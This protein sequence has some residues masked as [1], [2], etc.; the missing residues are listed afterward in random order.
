MAAEE[1]KVH[2][3]LGARNFGPWPFYAFGLVEFVVRKSP[4]F[5]RG[6]RRVLIFV[7]PS[8]A[9]ALRTQRDSACAGVAAAL[10]RRR[11]D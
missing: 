11:H 3:L 6:K 9:G 2:L 7:P 4:P 10:L 5:G 8:G 1:R